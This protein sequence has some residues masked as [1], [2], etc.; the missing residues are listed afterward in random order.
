[1]KK[2]EAAR[3]ERQRMRYALPY[4]VW[5]T[6]EGREV[7]FNRE[8]QA[9]WQRSAGDVTRANPREWV[10]GIDHDKTKF[11]YADDNAP[12][13]QRSASASKASIVRCRILL[14]EW[15]VTEDVEVEELIREKE[16]KC[17]P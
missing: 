11:L 16:N 8:Y 13:A 17:K 7:L 1:V 10:V 2:S 15:G 5:T 14:T 4:G 9:L 6:I 12:D 3:L